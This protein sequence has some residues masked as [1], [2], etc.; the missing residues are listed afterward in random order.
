MDDFFKKSNGSRVCVEQSAQ[1][2][3]KAQKLEFQ[4]SLKTGV[5]VKTEHS[6]IDWKSVWKANSLH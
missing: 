5:H 4:W 6:K 1:V 2:P 3:R